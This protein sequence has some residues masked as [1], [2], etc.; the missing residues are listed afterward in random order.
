MHLYALTLQKPSCI[1]KAVHGNFSGSKQQEIVVARGRI[2]EILK[3]DPNTGKLHSL[4][5]VDIFA[6]VRS[7]LPFKLTGSSKGKCSD[8]S[9][10]VLTDVR[11]FISDYLVVGSDSGRISI[12]EF[13]PQKNAFEKVGILFLSHAASCS[14]F[15]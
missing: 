4:H 1:T 10:P 2:L 3:P 9:N 15:F 8:I 13:N 5:S 11:A 7:V 6:L 12:L 14:M